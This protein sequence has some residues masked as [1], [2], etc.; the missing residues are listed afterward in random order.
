MNWASPNITGI[1]DWSCRL[2]FTLP[3][4]FYATKINKL[5]VKLKAQDD[6]AKIKYPIVILSAA[7]HG[8]NP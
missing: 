4:N 3:D 1:Y 2:S 6:S 8:P 5:V 7:N